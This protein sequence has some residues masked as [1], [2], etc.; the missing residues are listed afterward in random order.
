[1]NQRVIS[2]DFKTNI[3]VWFNNSMDRVSGVYKRKVQ[4]A[5]FFLSF[6]LAV[7][8]N[9]DSIVLANRLSHDSAL[10]AALVANATASANLPPSGS[11]PAGVVSLREREASLDSAIRQ[12][13]KLRLPIGWS[14]PGPDL[15]LP[16]PSLFG[17][18][19]SLRRHFV[20]WALT[21]FAASLGAPFWFDLLNRFINIRSS[22]KA[23]EEKP[24]DPKEL[25]QPSGPGASPAP[26]NAPTIS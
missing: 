6:V 5:L 4:Y 14:G 2:R 10:R 7:L 23:P 12:L 26:G 16:S 18:W 21:A 19:D 1:M 13:E 3:E 20:G 17:I 8:L 24:K 15:T 11:D 25:P 9:I 22:G